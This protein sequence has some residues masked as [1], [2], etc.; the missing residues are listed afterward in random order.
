MVHLRMTR[1]AKS[2]DV[3]ERAFSTDLHPAEKEKWRRELYFGLPGYMV[4]FFYFL[5]AR[6]PRRR[7]PNSWLVIAVLVLSATG[8]KGL[9]SA[10]ALNRAGL[11]YQQGKY[12]EALDVYREAVRLD[13]GFGAAHCGMANTL[14]ELGRYHEA[15]ESYR[16]ALRL[17][18]DAIR[19][20]YPLAVLLY[21]Q[22]EPDSAEAECNTVSGQRQAFCECTVFIAVAA[23]QRGNRAGSLRL[24]SKADAAEPGCINGVSGAR[25]VYERVREP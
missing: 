1:R 8:C 17:E 24:F 5:G 18:P 22:G 14:R 20:R 23:E 13:P 2:V 7:L 9:R 11:L 16:T 15:I 21:E 12:T 3:H 19:C 10:D 6:G 25:S 4:P